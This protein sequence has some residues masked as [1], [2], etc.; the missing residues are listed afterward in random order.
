M[1]PDNLR[2][3]NLF[4][5]IIKNFRLRPRALWRFLNDEEF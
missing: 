5:R 3:C 4:E 1:K 2:N